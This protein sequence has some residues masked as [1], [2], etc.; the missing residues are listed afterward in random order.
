MIVVPEWFFLLSV[1][2][3]GLLFGSMGNVIIWRVPRGESIVAPSSHC[4]SCGNAIR[5]YDNVPVLSW[6][7]LRARCRDCGASISARYPLVEA[8]SGLLWLLAGLLWGM[9]MRVGFG[10]AFF[11]ALLVLTFIDLDH[12]RLPNGLVALLAGIGVV[13]VALGVATGFEVVPL[14]PLPESGLLSS[15]MA[16]AALGAILGAGLS[17]LL[18]AAYSMVRGTTGLGMGDVKLLGALGIFLGPYVLMVLVIGS[19][20]G[21]I[22]SV[23]L[24][25][26]GADMSKTRI[27]FGP[28]LAAAAVVVC[29]VGTPLWTWYARLVLLV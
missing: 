7:I 6:L 16:Y 13:G 27:P 23:L 24:M 28:Y 29:V 11:Y 22:A 8:I 4:P 10:I 9:S 2:L 25:R 3:F 5:W 1:G 15:P 17:G 26:R 18:A 20:L 14:A 12:H 19:M 21:M